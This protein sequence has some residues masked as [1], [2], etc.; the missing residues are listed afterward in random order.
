M[1]D[2]NLVGSCKI[3]T[4]T[5]TDFANPVAVGVVGQTFHWKYVDVGNAQFLGQAT[6]TS[7]TNGIYQ[8]IGSNFDTVAGSS[9]SRFSARDWEFFKIGSDWYAVL[10][11]FEGSSSSLFSY[12]PTTFSWIEIN[13][14]PTTQAYDADA[15]TVDGETFLAVTENKLINGT[16]YSEVF[17][18]NGNTFVVDSIFRTPSPRNTEVFTIGNEIYAFVANQ[19][20]PSQLYK[21]N[22]RLSVFDLI[23]SADSG[24]LQNFSAKQF[25][26][27]GMDLLYVASQGTSYVYRLGI[28]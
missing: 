28:A 18:W 19:N 10:S 8:A 22:K 7:L 13:S 23:V 2:A 17:K 14:F 12:N 15:F 6:A 21:W 27:G 16:V 5:G 26:I 3:R 9:S 25:S 4:W 11:F 24:I 20:H 1:V